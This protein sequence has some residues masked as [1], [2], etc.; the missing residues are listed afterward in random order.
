M[1]FVAYNLKL[2]SGKGWKN[3]KELSERA[4]EKGYTVYCFSA[5]TGNDY[6]QIK[7]QYNLDFELLFCDE[8]TLKTIIR[9]NP[10]IVK[11]NKGT[12][13]GKWSWRQAKNVTLE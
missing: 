1:L 4:M 10:G 13:K 5:S 8:T 12:I 6:K 2:T 3:I 7:D 9:S 11:L